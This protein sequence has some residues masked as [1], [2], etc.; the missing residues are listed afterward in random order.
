MRTNWVEYPEKRKD[1][2]KALKELPE[3]FS[4]CY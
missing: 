3:G 1:L 2:R 4:F